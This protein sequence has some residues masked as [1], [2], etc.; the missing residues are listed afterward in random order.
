MTLS[1]RRAR[2]NDV[3]SIHRL[4]DYYAP[5]G[6]LLPRSLDERTERSSSFTIIS[7]ADNLT[8]CA[9]LEAFTDDLRE[10]R[11]L[12]VSDTAIGLRHRRALDEEI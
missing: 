6:Q 11:S 5:R 1:V 9:A 2:T 4:L 7:A 10:V 12:A 3:P 8:G